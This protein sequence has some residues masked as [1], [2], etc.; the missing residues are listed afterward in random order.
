MRE[1]SEDE[2]GHEQDVNA[3]DEQDG[4]SDEDPVP[5]DSHNRDCQDQEKLQ[6]AQSRLRN[7]FLDRLAEVLARVKGVPEEIANAYMVEAE[8]DHGNPRVEIRVTKDEGVSG[9]DMDYLRDLGVDLKRVARGKLA[10]S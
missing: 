3:E 9:G 6:M 8:D 7:R 10:T 5:W 4:I 2:S 1:D